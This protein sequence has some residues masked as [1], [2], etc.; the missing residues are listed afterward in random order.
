MANELGKFLKQSR[1][2]AELSQKELSKILGYE[3]SQFISNW[4]R[5]VSR[6]P[7]PMIKKLCSALL[8]DAEEYVTRLVSVIEKEIWCEIYEGEELHESL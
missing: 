1:K 3:S 5:G 6:V 7:H 4:E 2:S 8:I